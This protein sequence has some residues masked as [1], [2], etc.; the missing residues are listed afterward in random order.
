MTLDSVVIR[1]VRDD[2]R[3]LV[4]E[5]IAPF[6]EQQKLLPRTIDELDLLIPNGFVADADG[7]LIGFATLEVY[8]KKLAEVRSLVVAEE[9]QGRGLGRRLVE[10][11]VQRARERNVLEVMAISS[12]EQFFRACG[13]DFTLPGEKK[14]FFLQTGTIPA[15]HA[16]PPPDVL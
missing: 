7:R 8:S 11:C 13:F 12:S 9:F 15:L 3:G 2:E 10:A 6:V 4:L 1:P 5:L 16:S 14:A